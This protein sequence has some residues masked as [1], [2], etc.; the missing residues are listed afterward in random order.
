MRVYGAG[1]VLVSES[2]SR[3]A[4]SEPLAVEPKMNCTLLEDA[5]A[6][7]PVSVE[8]EAVRLYAESGSLASVS[9]E[10][11]IAIYEL[12]KL[13][14]TSWWQAE[15]AALRREE[16]AMKNARLTRIHNLTLEALEDRL[17][18]GDLVMKGRGFVRAKLSGR[19][20]ARISEA[21]FKQ[22]QL[23]NGEP[24]HIDNSNKKL[25]ELSQKLRA[26][27]AKDATHLTID[28]EAQ[29]VTPINRTSDRARVEPRQPEFA[30]HDTEGDD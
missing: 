27:G 10:L 5:R 11:G 17:E 28:M 29:D 23:L 24:T 6:L 26:L 18:H 25:E 8:L 1:G 4:T 30:G 12:Q 9:R 16:S 20:L 14:R 3:E 13:Q 19:D 7:A 22:R 15:L 2:P 21:V